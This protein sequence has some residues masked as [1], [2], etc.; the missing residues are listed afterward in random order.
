[1]KKF[2]E[3]PKCRILILNDMSGSSSLNLQHANYMFWFEQP[4]SPITRQQGV[5]RIYRPGQTKPVYIIDPFMSGTVDERIY[6]ANQ[7]GK[8]LLDQ[9]LKGTN[10]L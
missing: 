7:Q 4:D 6:Y 2:R 9:L 1:L 5:K 8:K 10:K 3:D